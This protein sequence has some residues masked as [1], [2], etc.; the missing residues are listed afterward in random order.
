MIARLPILVSTVA[1]AFVVTSAG[2]ATA[3]VTV[4]VILALWGPPVVVW[5]W[6]RK[7]GLTKVGEQE[8]TSPNG[9]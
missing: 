3:V 1:L 5:I 4:G 8:T 6:T 2:A 7:R 9:P